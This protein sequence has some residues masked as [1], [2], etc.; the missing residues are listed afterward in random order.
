M[1]CDYLTGFD[2]TIDNF[3]LECIIFGVP[4]QQSEHK[5]NQLLQT[6]C[7][8]CYLQ[9]QNEWNRKHWFSWL[10]ILFKKDFNYGRKYLPCNASRKII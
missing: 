9:K 8:I 6:I 4:R 10:P 5:I 3:V 1:P 2:I 7:K